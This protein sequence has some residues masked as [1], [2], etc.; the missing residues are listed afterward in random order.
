[1]KNSMSSISM[2]PFR[3]RSAFEREMEAL[4][5]PDRTDPYDVAETDFEGPIQPNRCFQATTLYEQPTYELFARSVKKWI[6][7]CVQEGRENKLVDG[8]ESLREVWDELQSMPTSMDLVRGRKIDVLPQYKWERTSG[9]PYWRTTK[10]TFKIIRKGKTVTRPGFPDPVPDPKKDDPKKRDDIPP[11]K[12]PG[13]DVYYFCTKNGIRY[14]KVKKGQKPGVPPAEAT[15]PFYLDYDTAL[16]QCIPAIVD[17]GW[18]WRPPG[19]VTTPAKQKDDFD[20]GPMVSVLVFFGAV[21]FFRK[22]TLYAEAIFELYEI[23]KFLD[24]IDPGGES[25]F[26]LKKDLANNR[27]S[28][29]MEK[30]GNAEVIDKV[31]D[32][33]LAKNK[34]QQKDYERFKS[35]IND[36]YV[37]MQN[38][39]AYRTQRYFRA[40]GHFVRGFFIEDTYIERELMK[41]GYVGLPNWFKGYDAYYQGSKFSI[42]KT[43]GKYITTFD[44]PGLISIKSYEPK[45]GLKNISIDY[46]TE[47]MGNWLSK[48]N[49]KEFERENIRIV[50]PR[51]KEVHLI[52]LGEEKKSEF[53]GKL[54]EIRQLFKDA[55]IV[56]K[57]LQYKK[58]VDTFTEL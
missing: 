38:M 3:E 49:F 33:L 55:K 26:H 2:V 18:I 35:L 17:P 57:V 36:L 56:L 32:D 21:I 8:N 44:N 23:K 13:V 10:I 42:R 12:E 11:K 51:E 15:S 53:A 46:L 41:N 6:R 5:G 37:K 48:M 14:L 34:I 20:L 58:S 43:L 40:A 9:Y 1:M 45:G 29:L 24:R 22:T 52:L 27:L 7:T 25:K 4:L 19:D 54:S 39:D 28:I 50:N 31:F 16:T 47:Q 30:R